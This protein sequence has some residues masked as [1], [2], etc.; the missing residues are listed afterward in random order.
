MRIVLFGEKKCGKSSFVKT[1]LKR[2][3]SDPPE[4][5]IYDSYK[6]RVKGNR[7]EVEV[8]IVDT[9]SPS[10]KFDA[11][12]F[13]SYVDMDVGLLCYDMSRMSSFDS[14]DKWIRELKDKASKAFYIL[15]GLKSD[16]RCDRLKT[17]DIENL[18]KNSD[19][20]ICH[21]ECSAREDRDSVLSIFDK[22]LDFAD[23]AQDER[24]RHMTEESLSR[25]PR[26][27]VKRGRKKKRRSSGSSQVGEFDQCC[28]IS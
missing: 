18:V 26:K 28:V 20:C 13:L 6:V 24:F 7:G 4:S 22:A 9:P 1:Y 25:N 15:C 10:S 27:S 11:F 2:F 14:V 16:A 21:M 5:T 17:K 12:R 19:G 8:N 3:P 23:E